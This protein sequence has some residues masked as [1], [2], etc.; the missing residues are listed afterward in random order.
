MSFK[1]VAP[2]RAARA[3]AGARPLAAFDGRP[4]AAASLW[5]DVRAFAA[6]SSAWTAR[7]SFRALRGLFL[8]R[9]LAVALND[10]LPNPRDVAP[11]TRL[12]YGAVAIMAV[13]LV[14]DLVESPPALPSLAPA[15]ERRPEWIESARAHG[16]FALESSALDGLDARY[17]VRRHRFGGGR[18]DELTFGNAESPGAYVRLS[19][20]RPGD[21]GMAEPDALE[22]VTALA[23]ESD[24]DA[25]LQET[26]GKVRTKFGDLPA[27]NMRIHVRSGW[28][29]CLA[30][31]GAWSDPRF[32]LVGWWCNSGPEMVALGE[33]ACLLDRAT[34]MS[35]G[36]DDQLA[37]FFARAE[38]KRN[39]CNAHGSFVSATPKL[40]NDWLHAKRNPQL[41][42][43]IV[44]R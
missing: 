8:L 43:R 2:V 16:A 28:R 24:I 26:S 20:Y 36:G 11:S 18:K 7:A 40:V 10:R 30:V 17:Q 32:G 13:I 6:A 1:P 41:R 5:R 29:N 14:N 37:E 27:V 44:G 39:F 22:A 19:F 4:G 12:A 31:A 25:D 3:L 38:L 34:L 15:A 42:G 9:D 35:A 21:E 23:A 33:F